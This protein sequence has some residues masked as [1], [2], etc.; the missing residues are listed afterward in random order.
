MTE[1]SKKEDVGFEQWPDRPLTPEELSVTTDSLGLG[2][3]P[4]I[5]PLIIDLNE[6]GYQTSASCSGDSPNH[7]FKDQRHG[8]KAWVDFKGLTK[9]M[10]T[11][12]M[13][14]ELDSIIKDNTRTTYRII[15][16]SDEV[17]KRR[18]KM[19]RDIAREEPEYLEELDRKFREQ[20]EGN[21]VRIEFSGPIS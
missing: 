1:V 10:L 18:A 9:R 19:R 15:T 2:I 21:D 6:A 16:F 5:L 17:R 8:R 11:E 7:P 3:D 13:V 20:E 12:E 14:E 4:D